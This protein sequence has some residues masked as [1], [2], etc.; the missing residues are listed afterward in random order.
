MSLL[1]KNLWVWGWIAMFIV[2]WLIF[3]QT[4]DMQGP[5]ASL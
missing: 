2:L 4:E 1:K 5:L 3:G